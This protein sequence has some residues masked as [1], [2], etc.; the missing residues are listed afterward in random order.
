MHLRIGR[1][2]SKAM[3]P[4]VLAERI[5]D[6]ANQLNLS[7]ALVSDDEE[8]IR[9]AR[10]DLQAA[11]KAKASTAYEAACNYLLAGIAALG[12]DGW[13]RADALSFALCFELAECETSRGR[14]DEAAMLVDD[15]LGRSRSK[16]DHALVTVQRMTLQMMR[17]EAEQVV[18]TGIESLALLGQ[19]VAERPSATQ[20][21]TECQNLYDTMGDRAIEHLADLPMMDDPETAAAMSIM[22]RIGLASYFTDAALHQT[23]SIRLVRLTLAHGLSESSIYGCAGLA[24]YLG[25]VFDRYADGE[26][27]ARAAVAIA[28][29]GGYLAFRAGAYVALQEATL[30]TRPVTEAVALLDQSVKLAKATGALLFAC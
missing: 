11:R 9:V 2:L 16:V 12:R 14:L 10:L 25:P 20:V 28:D 23:I 27:F 3:S 30:W 7:L 24:L 17:G 19:V 26:R 4:E 15:M 21:R 29:K 13:E 18:R 22:V 1:A 8:R 5:F 6:V